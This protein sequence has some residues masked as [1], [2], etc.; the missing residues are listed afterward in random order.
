MNFLLLL[1]VPAKDLCGSGSSERRQEIEEEV[2]VQKIR[3]QIGIRE[4]R[5]HYP[6][7]RGSF[8]LFLIQK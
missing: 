3:R 5:P 8:Y 7:S 6:Y 2:D 4:G 1:D